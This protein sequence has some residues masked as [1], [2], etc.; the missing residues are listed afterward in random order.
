MFEGNEYIWGSMLRWIL[1]TDRQMRSNATNRKNYDGP[2]WPEDP[3]LAVLVLYWKMSCSRD[4][5]SSGITEEVALARRGDTGVSERI[6]EVG[7]GELELRLL[8]SSS[9]M[10][11]V[12]TLVHRILGEH[13]R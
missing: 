3:L 12:R 11:R 9:V 5:L 10:P 8:D 7:I 1:C 2:L 13:T 4:N 6:G